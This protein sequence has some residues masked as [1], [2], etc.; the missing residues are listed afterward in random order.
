PENISLMVKDLGLKH[1]VITSVTRDDLPDKGAGQFVE[2]VK[3]ILKLKPAVTIEVLTPDFN[4]DFGLLEKVLQ[5]PI[6]VFNHNVETV[7]RLYPVARKQ[8]DYRRSLDILKFASEFSSK[9]YFVKSGFMVGL[10]E[11]ESEIFELMNA[12]FNAGVEILT[13]GQ[14]L[15]PSLKHL[16]VKKYYSDNEFDNLSG[17]GEN[18]GFKR[19]FSGPFVRSSFNSEI[20]LSELK[21]V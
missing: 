17:F 4:G 2:T 13:I 6:S 7:E 10:G 19:V 15:R 16:E 3:C 12:L 9:N 11:L 20:I 1:V 8:A 5:L 18:I 21:G 14:Y